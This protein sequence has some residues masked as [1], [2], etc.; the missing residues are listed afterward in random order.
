MWKQKMKICSINLTV[1]SVAFVTMMMLSFC[2]QLYGQENSTHSF[3][4]TKLTVPDIDTTKLSNS[5]M[6]TPS[7]IVKD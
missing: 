3:D 4:Y 6:S 5:S 2:S 7:T 1:H